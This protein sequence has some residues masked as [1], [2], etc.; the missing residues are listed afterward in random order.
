MGAPSRCVNSARVWVWG[1]W[2]ACAWGTPPPGARRGFQTRPPT[3]T[4]LP[5]NSVS[6]EHQP[7]RGDALLNESPSSHRRSRKGSGLVLVTALMM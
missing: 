1:A 3:K 6:D 4:R 7:N 2:G 5:A